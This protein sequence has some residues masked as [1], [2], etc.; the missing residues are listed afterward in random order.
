MH[1]E[2]K[3][4]RF[5]GASRQGARTGHRPRGFYPLTF[6]KGLA[7]GSAD[8]VPGVSGGTIALICGVYVELVEAIRNVVSPHLR[9]LLRPGGAR[10]YLRAI[11]LDLML[12]LGLGILTALLLLSKLILTLLAAWPVL[13]WSFFLGLILASAWYVARGVK[14]WTWARGGWLTLGAALG[15][16]VSLA[17]PGS[18]PDSPLW[19]FLCGALAI[20][21]MILP[22]ISGSFVL[23]LLGKYRLVLE[24]LHAFDLSILLPFALGCLVGIVSFSHLLSWLLRRFYETAV[25]LLTGFMLGAMIRLWPWQMQEAIGGAE[26]A[27]ATISLLSPALYAER[28]GG[29]CISLGWALL[30]LL[31]GSGLVVLLQ[32]LSARGSR[33]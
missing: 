6:L 20:C 14:H 19:F 1:A 8:V 21:A 24:A 25:A 32:R 26:T 27:E 31:L 23:L 28:V 9:G 16:W 10:A 3:N 4:V 17:V 15:L 5:A 11:H 29:P 13:V 2:K 7:M 12:P 30:M 18:L 33:S 22:G